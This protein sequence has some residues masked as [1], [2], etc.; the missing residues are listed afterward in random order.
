MLVWSVNEQ[1]INFRTGTICL[2][3]L[4]LKKLVYLHFYSER[5]NSPPKKIWPRHKIFLVPFSSE[6]HDVPITQQCKKKKKKM[7]KMFFL[8][9]YPTQ[10]YRVGVQQIQFFK[11]GPT[12]TWKIVHVSGNKIFFFFFF[13]APSRFEYV[14]KFLYTFNPKI[15]SV[16]FSYSFIVAVRHN[17]PACIKS[18]RGVLQCIKI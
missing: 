1:C 9:T 6:N 14:F 5:K 4:W 11:D 17:P 16:L 13:M 18:W 7:K 12:D 10:K 2:N 15:F 3:I 8:P